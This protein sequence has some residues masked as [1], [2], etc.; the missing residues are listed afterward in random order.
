M[1]LV[2]SVATLL[3]ALSAVRLEQFSEGR[4]AQGLYVGP[5]ADEPPVIAQLHAFI[6][7]QGL[8]LR[9]KHHEIYLSDMRRTAPDR[10]KTILRQ[11]VA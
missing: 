9:G 5:Y 3:P 10:L 11:P 2:R 8:R 4:V 1:N 7:D 6:Q